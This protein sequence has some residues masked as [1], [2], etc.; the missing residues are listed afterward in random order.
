M[1]ALR[2]GEDEW[3][4]IFGSNPIYVSGTKIFRF[5]I[6]IRRINPDRSGM[7]I[8]LAKIRDRYSCC[9]GYG[10]SGYSYPSQTRAVV[11]Q[12]EFQ[13]N[14]IIGVHLDNSKRQVSFYR[15]GSL[16]FINSRLLPLGIELYPAVYMHYVGDEV[17]IRC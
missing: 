14:D 8:G 2:T 5:E 6:K 1:T 16:L 11:D 9:W 4:G 12:S 3:R 15:N 13:A 17:R 10:G 7:V